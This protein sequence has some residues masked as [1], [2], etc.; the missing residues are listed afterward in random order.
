MK[1]K[2]KEYGAFILQTSLGKRLLSLRANAIKEG[3][4]LLSAAEVLR[5]VRR[6]RIG[7]QEVNDASRND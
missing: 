1:R 5:E 2:K 6:R 7:Y 4:P 3:M